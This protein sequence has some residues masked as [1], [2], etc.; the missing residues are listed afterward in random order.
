MKAQIVSLPGYVFLYKCNCL[1]CSEGEDL[2]ENI[3]ND[4]YGKNIYTKQIC[5]I[6]QAEFD[7]RCI[8]QQD[9]E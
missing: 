8:F 3:G 2:P 9:K 5:S 7:D 1:T 6:A 4:R